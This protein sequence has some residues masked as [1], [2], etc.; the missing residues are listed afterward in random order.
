MRRRLRFSL[1]PTG[2]LSARTKREPFK[3]GL[4][5]GFDPPY[6]ERPGRGKV[7]AG[8]EGQG[9]EGHDE[10]EEGMVEREE[11]DGGLALFQELTTDFS[12]Q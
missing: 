11:S 1:D 5:S 4:R 8:R 12:L 7:G 2:C 3:L 6:L 10:S 9:R